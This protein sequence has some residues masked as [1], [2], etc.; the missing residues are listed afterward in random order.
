MVIFILVGKSE[1]ITHINEESSSKVVIDAILFLQK[2]TLTKEGNE[3]L[4]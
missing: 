3:G 4:R 2:I 1:Q